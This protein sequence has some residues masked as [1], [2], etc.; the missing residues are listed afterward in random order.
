MTG[1]RPAPDPP[2]ASNGCAR[3][4]SASS[5]F[6]LGR[7]CRTHTPPALQS[8]R[9]PGPC[10]VCGGAPTA[11]GMCPRADPPW[12]APARA[13]LRRVVRRKGGGANLAPPFMPQPHAPAH[14][15]VR[16]GRRRGL[17]VL[18][19][20]LHRATRGVAG[21]ARFAHC[22]GLRSPWSPWDFFILQTKK[23]RRKKN[24]ELTR[25]V[26]NARANL[27]RRQGAEFILR[28]GP[29]TRGLL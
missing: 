20:A 8:R 21:F 17:C 5:R 22:L 3:A 14:S 12:G 19:G 7:T 23:K 1:T 4:R 2:H 26:A 28:G 16:G 24:G 27:H 15:R 11:R 25:L 29:A 10:A 13:R 9:L 6:D 18:R